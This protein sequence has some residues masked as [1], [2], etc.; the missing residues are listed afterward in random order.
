VEGFGPVWRAGPNESHVRRDEVGGNRITNQLV[1][2]LAVH[3]GDI[4]RAGSDLILFSCP[5]LQNAR[6]DVD[7]KLQVQPRNAP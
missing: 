2:K 7:T 6:S 1:P 4:S 5:Q 3:L